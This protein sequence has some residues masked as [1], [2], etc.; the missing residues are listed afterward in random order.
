MVKILKALY[1]S[2]A[3]L[4]LFFLYLEHKEQVLEDTIYSKIK[5]FNTQD[6]SFEVSKNNIKC[7]TLNLSKNYC[8]IEKIKVFNIKLLQFFKL[9]ELVTYNLD[10]LN[11]FISNNSQQISFNF[12]KS[13]LLKGHYIEINDM[14]G[15]M[16]INKNN[17]SLIL[18]KFNKHNIKNVDVPE[19][20]FNDVFNSIFYSYSFFDKNTTTVSF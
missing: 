5:T 16:T 3:F 18:N 11:E 15:K 12:N 8:S 9:R 10:E 7:S 14:N 20:S 17:L 6:I 1:I 13:S 2:S 19:E 4:F